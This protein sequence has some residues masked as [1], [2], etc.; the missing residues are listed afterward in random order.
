M[1]RG[2]QERYEVAV[3]NFPGGTS[4]KV[5]EEIENLLADKPGCIIIH[6]R[7]NDITNDINSLNLVK[8]VK[9]VK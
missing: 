5:L 8:K 6:A 1:K 3:K 9:D 2:Y 7:T 4:K